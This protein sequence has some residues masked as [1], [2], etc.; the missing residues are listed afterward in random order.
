MLVQD[1][2]ILHT[3]TNAVGSSHS[4]PVL[5]SSEPTIVHKLCVF[6][7][8]AAQ[9]VRWCPLE[10]SNIYLDKEDVLASLVYLEGALIS[11]LYAHSRMSKDYWR[12]TLVPLRLFVECWWCGE[13]SYRASGCMWP[14]YVTRKSF[15]A[16]SSLSRPVVRHVLSVA[17][18]Q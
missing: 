5:P 10:E 14:V 2:F 7:L 3:R 18:A 15:I 13:S 6:R 11:I 12:W 9:C 16:C 4:K 17:S 1:F 8:K